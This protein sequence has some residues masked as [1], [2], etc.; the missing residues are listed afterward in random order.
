[1][2]ETWYQ[3]FD[4][5]RDDWHIG[6]IYYNPSLRQFVGSAT[7]VYRNHNRA[8]AHAAELENQFGKEYRPIRVR[9]NDYDVTEGWAPWPV[10]AFFGKG[11]MTM[12]VVPTEAGD[13][14]PLLSK[15]SKT[16][17]YALIMEDESGRSFFYGFIR[18]LV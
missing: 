16:Y 6:F 8:Q 11:T 13:S 10:N 1:M 17:K 15:A 3:E 9:F 14:V 18:T 12:V 4:S 2:S 5:R 7:P